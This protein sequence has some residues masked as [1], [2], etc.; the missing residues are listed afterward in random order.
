MFKEDEKRKVKDE[1]KEFLEEHFEDPES[2]ILVE[3]QAKEG[4]RKS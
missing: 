2:D 1:F 4:K 3:K